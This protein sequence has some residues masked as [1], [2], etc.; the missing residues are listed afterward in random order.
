MEMLREERPSPRWFLRSLG[1]TLGPLADQ[2]ILEGLRVGDFLGS[3][4]VFSARDAAWTTLREHPHFASLHFWSE[5]PPASDQL[6]RVPSP[7]TLRARASAGLALAP[8][9]PVATEEPKPAAPAEEPALVAPPVEAAVEEALFPPLPACIPGAV[10]TETALSEATVPPLL[11]EENDDLEAAARELEIALENLPEPAEPP[12]AAAPPMA[13]VVNEAADAAGIPNRPDWKPVFLADPTTPW[14]APKD[15]TAAR[16]IQIRLERPLL[17][18]AGALVVLAVLVIGVWWA[19]NKTRDLKDS[20]L[21]DPSSPTTVPY[22]AGDPVP[23]L[24][25]PT[26]PQRE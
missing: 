1:G 24:K 7:R 9:L 18:A 5:L 23:P 21:P 3:D 11:P 20:R 8:P 17:A 15:N 14:E 26:R 4:R 16:G 2:D 6:S 25:A 22:D 13:P 19:A 12:P 10:E